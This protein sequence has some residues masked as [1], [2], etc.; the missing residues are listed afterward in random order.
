VKSMRSVP[1]I[2]RSF[3]LGPPMM[4]FVDLPFCLEPVRE[5]VSVIAITLLPKLMRAFGDLFFETQSLVH[6]QNGPAFP[7]VLSLFHYFPWLFVVLCS[8]VMIFPAASSTRR[9]KR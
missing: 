5:I 2:G 1:G 4:P 8:S 3:H 6:V 9:P 7:L